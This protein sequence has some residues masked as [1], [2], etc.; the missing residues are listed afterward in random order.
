MLHQ[1]QTLVAKA[2]SMPGSAETAIVTG[3]GSGID[4]TV[5]ALLKEECSVAPSLVAV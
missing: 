3:A 4:A 2:K 1:A 5:A